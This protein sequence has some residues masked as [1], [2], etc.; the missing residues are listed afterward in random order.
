MANRVLVADGNRARARRV[1][2]ACVAQGFETRHVETGSAALEIALADVPQL[3]VVAV[4]LPLIDGP[5]L[6]EIL[7]ANPRTAQARCLFLGR[8]PGRPASPFD[9]V[10]PPSAQA[11]DIAAQAATMLARQMRMDAVRRESSAR[12]EVEGTLAQIPL[13]DLIQLFHGNRRSGVVELVRTPDASGPVQAGAVWLH[14]GNVVH[15]SAGVQVRGEKALFRL[16]AWRDG[17]FTFTADAIAPETTVTTPTRVLLLEGLRQLDES[18]SGSGGLPAPSARVRLA[19]PANEIPH[20]VHPVTQEVLLL[21]EMYER[22]ADVVDHCSHPDY[23]VLR[24]LQTLAERGLLVL[25]RD[26]SEDDSRSASWLDPVALRRLHDFLQAG[27]PPGRA[28]GSAKL[29][30]AGSDL[31]VTRDFM[32]LLG[33][34]PGLEPAPELEAGRVSPD[35]LLRLGRLRLGEG[36]HLELF[37]VPIAEA[38]A[39]AWPVLAHGALGVLLVQAHPVSASEARLRPLLQALARRAETRLFR[40]LLLRKGDRVAAEEVQQRL[41]LLDRSSLFLLPLE[42]GKDPRSLLATL[43][44]RVLP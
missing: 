28:S 39:P 33:T 13:A 11:E 21:L 7:R 31:E 3:L 30:V 25:S 32:R 37:Q 41:N 8:L 38:F 15:A 5:R 35:D 27:R 36:P 44:A 26:P 14:D 24:T 43:I 12:R 10:L 16:L 20:A 19:V 9:E 34:L 23:Q 1:V 2:D 29:L 6:A 4:E 18:E 42:N 22:V 17:R 40:V